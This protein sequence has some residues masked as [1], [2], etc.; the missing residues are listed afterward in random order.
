M[1][2]YQVCRNKTLLYQCMSK[3]PFFK[4]LSVS[5]SSCKSFWSLFNKLKKILSTIPSLTHNN[6]TV[7]DTISK[8]NS[9]N[10]FFSQCFNSSVS[11]LSLSEIFPHFQMDCPSDLL[12]TPENNMQLISQL[13]SHTSTGPD[14]ISS[15]MLK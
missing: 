6:L 3:A 7:T 12:C 13:P 15:K 14:G 5:S 4:C 1:S 9:I 11:P 10:D 2:Q 8:A